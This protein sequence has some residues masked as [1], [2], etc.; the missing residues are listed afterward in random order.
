MTL[1]ILKFQ[2]AALA[3]MALEATNTTREGE[4]Q[5]ISR[6]EYAQL[7]FTK[8]EITEWFEVG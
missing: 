6:V 7:I 3:M 5:S 2:T 8:D 4:Y 1:T